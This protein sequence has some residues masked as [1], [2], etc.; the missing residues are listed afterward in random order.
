MK[1]FH[2]LLALIFIG[3]LY[4]ITIGLGGLAKQNSIVNEVAVVKLIITLISTP[5]LLF[6][7]IMSYG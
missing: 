6:L 4:T 3:F 5:S 1:G 2:V 7:S